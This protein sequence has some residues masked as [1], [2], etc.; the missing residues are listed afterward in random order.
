MSC[1]LL[2]GNA[3]VPT[4]GPG[5]LVA[6][7]SQFNVRGF[8]SENLADRHSWAYHWRKLHRQ[9]KDCARRTSRKRPPSPPVTEASTWNPVELREAWPRDQR[10]TLPRNSARQ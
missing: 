9:D 4:H 8:E 3:S 5:R 1:F 2:S 7:R 10:I 6:S